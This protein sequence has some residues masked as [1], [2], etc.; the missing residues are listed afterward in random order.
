MNIQNSVQRPVYKLTFKNSKGEVIEYVD[1]NTNIMAKMIGPEYSTDLIMTKGNNFRTWKY[2]DDE[3]LVTLVSGDYYLQVYLDG[4]VALSY[5][6]NLLGD[7]DDFDAGNGDYDLTKT[8]FSVTSISGIAGKSYDVNIEFRTKENKRWNKVGDPT[9]FTFTNSLKLSSSELEVKTQNGGKKGQFIINVTQKKSTETGKPNILTSIYE[10]GTIGQTLSITI[11]CDDLSSLVVDNTCL[12]SSTELKSGTVLSIPKITFVPYDKYG[13]VFTD[14]F[15]TS[16]FSQDRL[17]TLININHSADAA[18]VS[19]PVADATNKKLS[20]TLSTQIKGTLTLSSIFISGTKYTLK[21]VNG[22]IDIKYTV[23][24]IIG[25]TEGT[26]GNTFT[27]AIYPKDIY[28]NTLDDLSTSDFSKFKLTIVNPRTGDKVVSDASLKNTYIQYTTSLTEAGDVQFKPTLSSSGESIKCTKC[29]AKVKIA[30]LDYTKTKVYYN[31]EELIQT[32]PFRVDCSSSPKFTVSFFDQYGNQIDN[33]DDYSITS[34]FTGNDADINFCTEKA[35]NNYNV[36]VCREGENPRKWFYLVNGDYEMNIINQAGTKL[37]YKLDLFGSEATDG[38]NGPVNP[39]LTQFS[40]SSLTNTA[41]EQ[42]EFFIELKADDGK[43]KNYWYVDPTTEIIPTFKKEKCSSNVIIAEKPGQYYVQ[44]TCTQSTLGADSNSLYLTIEG[45]KVDH[46]VTIA[47]NPNQATVG[48]FIDS[49]KQKI[50]ESSLSEANTDNSYS[51]QLCLYDK[52][53][54]VANQDVATVTYSIVPPSEHSD[55]NVVTSIVKNSDYTFKVDIQPIY[56]GLYTIKS[57][58]FSKDYTFSTRPGEVYA[59]NSVMFTAEESAIAG[60]AVKAYI[61]PYDKNNNYVDPSKYITVNPFSVSYK[62]QV[63]GTYVNYIDIPKSQIESFSFGQKTFN[64]FAYENV[65]T[66]KDSNYYR[67]TMG[68]SELKCLRCIVVVNAGPMSFTN[69]KLMRFD[70]SSGSFQEITDAS[71]ED[72]NLVDIIY[73]IYPRDAYDNEIETITD[74]NK[75]SIT[76]EKDVVYPLGLFNTDDGKQQYAE[77]QKK[78]V[79]GQT[80]TY[81]TLTAGKYTVTFSDGTTQIVK[82]VTLKGRDTDPGASNKELDPQNTHINSE[83]LSYVAGNIGEMFLE[84][85]TVNN[86]RKNWW[87]NY[88]FTIEN[89][90][91]EEEDP[92]F[93]YTQEKSGILGVFYITVQSTLANTYPIAKDCR[94]KIYLDGE[95]IKALS[96]KMEVSPNVIAKTTVKPEYVKEGNTLLDGN[97]DTPYV[98]VM[99]TFDK[100]NNLV[101]GDVDTIGLSCTRNNENVEMTSQLDTKT[102]S[103]E[104]IVNNTISG[105]YTI[106]SKNDKTDSPYLEKSLSFENKHGEVTP[107]NSQ[108]EVS[109][110]MLNAGEKGIITIVPMDSYGNIIPGNDAKGKFKVEVKQNSLS[111][112]TI[113]EENVV[114]DKLEYSTILTKA[115]DAEWTIKF[116]DEEVSGE[117]SFITTVN[118]AEPDLSKTL[119]SAVNSLGTMDSFKN[120]T[121]I[122]A[123]TTLPLS[124]HATLSDSYDN[125]ITTIP[126]EMTITKTVLQGNDMEP[127]SLEITTAQ[128]NEIQL[129][130]P[131]ESIDDYKHLVSGDSY[132]VDFTIEYDNI[133]S[134][135]HYN[136]LLTSDKDDTGHGNGPYLAENTLI[137]CSDSITLEAGETKEMIILLRT[138]KDLLY[139][140]EINKEAVFQY[141]L[142]QPDSTFSFKRAEGNTTGNFTLTISSTYASTNI[143][144]IKILEK[145]AEQAKA[146]KTISLTI[147]PNSIPDPENT[148]IVTSPGEEIAAG[149]TIEIKFKIADTYNNQYIDNEE[150]ISH[151]SLTQNEIKMANAQFILGN[152]HETYSA[153][154]LPTYPPRKEIINIKYENPDGSSNPLFKESIITTVASEPDFSQSIIVTSNADEMEAG[155]KLSINATIYDKQGICIEKDYEDGKLPIKVSV[156]GPLEDVSKQL[157][158]VY[159]FNKEPTASSCNNKF[160]LNVPDDKVYNATGTYTI[161]VYN[162][163]DGM[164]IKQY[165]QSLNPGEYDIEHFNVVYAR[166]D[167]NPNEVL[168]GDKIELNITGKDKYDNPQNSKLLDLIMVNCTLDRTIRGDICEVTYEEYT[169][170]TLFVTMTIMRT[171]LFEFQYTYNKNIINIKEGPKS[172]MIVPGVCSPVNPS[173]DWSKLTDVKTPGEPKTFRI[174][175]YD[176]FKNPV[177]IGGLEFV[178][179]TTL[180][181]EKTSTNVQSTLVDN[182]NGTYDV[183]LTPPLAGNYTINVTLG[184]DKYADW[185]FT[186]ESGATKCSGDKP[187]AC[188]NAILNPEK[189]CVSNLL[190]CIDDKYRNEACNTEE[191]PFY[192]FSDNNKNECVSSITKCACPAGY[193]KCPWMGYCVPEELENVMCPFTL[194]INC[195][196]YPGYT[197]SCKDGICR[198]SQALGPSQRVCPIGY[199]LCADLTCQPSYSQCKTYPACADDEVQCIDQSCASDQSKCPTTIT[200]SD[201]SQVVCP[202]GSCVS[203]EI[204]CPA[205]PQCTNPTPYLCANNA[206]STSASECPKSI[207]CG[208]TYSLCSDMICRHEC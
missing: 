130:I 32:E 156:T 39:A 151:M 169:S 83:S 35:N 67:A 43:R 149:K 186:I 3:D 112:I 96:P 47:V 107:I 142:S 61:I 15:S 131:T 182:G 20:L 178:V 110:I 25:S 126:N 185:N 75:Y 28:S 177:T 85:R 183:S 37:T 166:K 202:D 103:I 129:N 54:N 46:K 5:P 2:K 173:V 114:N 145:K 9:K 124:L 89:C 38:S 181:I 14:L 188:P 62:Y 70:T 157:S 30:E 120:N 91:S 94:L 29:A 200:C 87:G 31:S 165:T 122:K 68:N 57:L 95:Y 201:P 42:N 71:V 184:Y 64:T 175:C 59:T 206:C 41:G 164:T 22:P 150:A 155:Q 136:V 141:E 24:E 48:Y 115:G 192:C 207:S 74:L 121:Q 146:V 134:S 116:N 104:Y 168:A 158:F 8:F 45:V 34:T 50:P 105:I 194:P 180:V 205:L 135:F 12:V 66:H 73:R 4:E 98:F 88:T 174:T 170:G 143:L 7:G 208:H 13:N 76:L 189:A 128:R 203:S 190:D 72:N 82:T 204:Y 60:D 92:S 119:V 140:N 86:L 139:N 55:A 123:Q 40:V 17:S 63:D 153:I 113:A 161:N 44:V 77:F 18:V 101:L 195:K 33:I 191:A 16:T 118:P 84:V 172:V 6:L 26:A 21:V 53:N 78:D 125:S 197:T 138:A 111:T 102:G 56:S 106:S 97:A 52:Y 163:E 193:V 148:V 69:S 19:T 133:T 127:I 159:S 81:N 199:V 100:Y 144:T 117:K 93:T 58:F 179:V 162:E 137:D 27:F 65:L 198:S 36:F 152:D 49:N 171:G 99:E 176:E 23:A 109:T 80:Y 51:L 11:K 167:F 79:E 132:T 147:T 108:I 187:Y 10:R 90:V 196:K 154:Y 160:V 1:P